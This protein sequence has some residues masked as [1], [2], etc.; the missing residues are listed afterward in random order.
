[1]NKNTGWIFSIFL[2]TLLAVSCEPEDEPTTVSGGDNQSIFGTW[3]GV[4]E[5]GFPV[6]LKVE[7]SWD[8]IFITNYD[9]TYLINGDTSTLF[10]DAPDGHGYVWADTFNFKLIHD[11][12]NKGLSKGKFWNSNYLAGFFEINEF[13]SIFDFNYTASKIGNAVSIH[14]APQYSLVF[15]DTQAADYTY[16]KGFYATYD[17]LKKQDQIILSSIV[18]YDPSSSEIQENLLEIRLGSLAE[19]FSPEELGQM[20]SV[21]YRPYSSGASDGIEIIW[22]DKLE[23]YKTWS[24]SFGTGSQDGSLFNISELLLISG[25]DSDYQLYKFT[26]NFNCILYDAEGNSKN[27]VSA[28]YLGLIGSG[29]ADD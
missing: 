4:T 14:S 29:S 16:T 27:V 6:Q 26:A 15:E 12:Q 7:S 3:A 24:T 11:N 17:T 18:F 10:K 21:G 1:M 22:R 2:I 9:F 19:G 13:G 5:Q 28:F 23:N 25:S 8:T 20:L